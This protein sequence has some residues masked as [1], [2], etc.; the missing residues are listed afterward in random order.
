VRAAVLLQQIYAKTLRHNF[1]QLPSAS[2]CCWQLAATR[3]STALRYF[4][5]TFQPITL[6]F[7]A[8]RQK[9]VQPRNQPRIRLDTAQ[10]TS[11][12]STR[13]VELVPIADMDHL[14]LNEG[15]H[16]YRPDESPLIGD[17]SFDCFRGETIAIGHF[18]MKLLG[19]FRK[20]VS[21]YLHGL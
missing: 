15:P 2:S 10:T 16:P 1:L 3:T 11:T 14:L 7:S 8:S 18:M 9:P 21:H 17:Q 4:L 6:A 19:V 5:Q 12:S 20:G 13:L